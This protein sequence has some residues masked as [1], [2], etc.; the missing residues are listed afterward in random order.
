[1]N[2]IIPII[3]YV[4]TSISVFI[5]SIPHYFGD[6]IFILLALILGIVLVFKLTQTDGRKRTKSILDLPILILL[7]FA[8]GS[9][10]YSVNAHNSLLIYFKLASLGIIFFSIGLIEN[11][12]KFFEIMDINSHSRVQY[13][14]YLWYT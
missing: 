1:M 2:N 11:R 9:L 4:M 13:L 5:P 12:R 14:V 3:L 10:T 6:S 8:T 7:L